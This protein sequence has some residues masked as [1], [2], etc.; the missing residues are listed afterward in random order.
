VV[1]L[2]KAGET[3]GEQVADRIARG[4]SSCERISLVV[5]V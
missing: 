2:T 3:G 4:L 5:V 1:A